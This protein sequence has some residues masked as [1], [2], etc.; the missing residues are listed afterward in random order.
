MFFLLTFILLQPVPLYK[1]IRF[2]IFTKSLKIK[3]KKSY[4][5]S[6]VGG[7][8]WVIFA[9]P[10]GRGRVLIDRGVSAYTGH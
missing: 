2:G 5:C 8:S 10:G 7:E 4:S 6:R 3:V 1:E 9:L